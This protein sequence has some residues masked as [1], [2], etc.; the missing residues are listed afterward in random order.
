MAAVSP[1]NVRSNIRNRLK[2]GKISYEERPI[3]YEM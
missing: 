3:V 1:K 2:F